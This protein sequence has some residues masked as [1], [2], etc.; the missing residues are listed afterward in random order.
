[1]T[2]DKKSLFLR[3]YANLPLDS[4]KEVVAVVEGEPISWNVAKIEIENDTATGK[5][6]LEFIITSKIIN[7]E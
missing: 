4:R 5:K 1:M 3:V 2:M 6:V 7:Q